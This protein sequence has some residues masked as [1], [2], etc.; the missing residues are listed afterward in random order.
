MAIL[1]NIKREMKGSYIGEIQGKIYQ[2][3]NYR[4]LEKK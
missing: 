1:Y 4:K 3:P 2:I